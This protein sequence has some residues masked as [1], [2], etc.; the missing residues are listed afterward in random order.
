LDR[1]DPGDLVIINCADGTKLLALFYK[2][3]G[4]FW[5]EVLFAEQFEYMQ[6]SDLQKA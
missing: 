1:F 2:K 4:Y 5:C 3:T 6:L